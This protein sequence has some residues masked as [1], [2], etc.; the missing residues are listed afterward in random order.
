MERGLLSDKSLKAHYGDVVWMYLFQDFSGSPTDRAAER[1]AVR[2]G[3]SSWPQHLLIDPANLEILGSTGRTLERFAAAV[4]RAETKLGGT[5][6]KQR[7]SG[8]VSPS[9]RALAAA[10]A[11]A[12]KIVTAKGTS[13]A[14][15]HVESTDRVVRYVAV[16]RLA[17]TDPAAVVAAAKTLLAVPHDQLRFAV[18]EVLAQ[19]GT[20][21]LAE[22][23]AALVRNP[24]ASRNPNVVRCRAA[25]AL[26]RCGTAA[27]LD[28]LAGFASSGNWRNSLTRLAI[29][30]VREIARREKPA[31]PR[32]TAIL[33]D[34]F[35]PPAK[36][37]GTKAG[38]RRVRAVEHL[39][40]TV[41]DALRSITRRKVAFP[42]AYDATSRQKLIAAWTK[43]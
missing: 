10:D 16:R 24:G 40:R 34:A 17:K 36:D 43:R 1:V 41:H 8:E 2:F 30:A 12:D 31:K 9:P 11:I 18:C 3:I 23:L 15:K 4:R 28:A 42:S 35:P 19:H 21:D 38:K 32:A 7:R 25:K 33:R 37:D 26:G 22:P 6:G 14:K 20:T 29:D 39:A 27:S 5:K 13:L